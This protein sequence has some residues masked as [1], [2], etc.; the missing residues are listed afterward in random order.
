MQAENP[1][2]STHSLDANPFEDPPLQSEATRAEQLRQRELDLE[3][4]E[5][6]LNQRADHLRKHGRNNWPFCIDLLDFSYMQAQIQQSFHSSSTPSQT[7]FPR[8]PSL[9]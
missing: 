6:E 8:H 2:A 5:V 7:K 4:R 9:S 3:R 1:F